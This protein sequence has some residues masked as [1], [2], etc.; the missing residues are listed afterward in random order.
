MQEKNWGGRIN[1][2]KGHVFGQ[3]DT[4]TNANF[5]FGEKSFTKKL[6]KD[7]KINKYKGLVF[8]AMIFHILGRK[9]FD[10]A[11]SKLLKCACWLKCCICVQNGVG[12]KP[13]LSIPLCP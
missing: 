6:N 12:S 5:S 4:L 9:Y 10:L 3:K 8:L 7:Q 2:K 13:I 11:Y 1:F